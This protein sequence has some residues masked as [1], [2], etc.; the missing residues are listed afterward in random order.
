MSKKINGLVVHEFGE[1]GDLS[2]IFIHGFPYNY[3]MWMKQIE[4]LKDQ[5]H[6]LAYDVRGFGCSDVGDGQYTIDSMVDDLEMLLDEREIERPILCGFSMGGYV[7]LRALDRNLKRYV[8]AILINTRAQADSNQAKVN[9]AAGIRRINDE[10]KEGFIQDFVPNCF[11]PEHI[12]KSVNFYTETLSEALKSDAIGVKGGLL[13][14]SGRLDLR[15][16]LGKMNLPALI[17]AG[18][19]D[20]LIPLAEMED[21]S[22]KMPNAAFAVAHAA[23]HMSPLENDQFVN[24]EILKYLQDNF[25]V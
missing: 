16:N 5:Y 17:I 15:E 3:K 12:D 1:K 10:G 7:T 13:A 9:R 22:K 2:L 21:M 18:E 6:C 24:Q 23:A 25:Y 4:S 19:L 20:A 8:G 11:V 14:M